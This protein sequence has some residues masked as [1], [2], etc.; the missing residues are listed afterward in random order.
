MATTTTQ[1]EKA[2]RFQE[3]H[4]RQG[5][6]F[7]PNPWDAGSAR[8]LA[9]LGFE[10][11][12]TSSGASAAVFGRRDGR[13]SRE[14]ALNQIRIIAAATDL[15]VSGDLEGGF[16]KDPKAV[17]ETIRLAAEAGLVGG[18][19]EDFTGDTTNPL[20]DIGLATERVAAAVEATKSLPFKFTL[21]ARAENFV[22]GK[23]DLD[24]TIRRLQA[25][26]KTGADV[27]FAPA[28][29][30]LATVRAVCSAVSKP[31]N[32]MVG[33][34]GKSFTAAELIEAGVK[35]ISFASSL[36][37]AAITGLV[38]AATEVRK[39]GTFRYLEKTLTGAELYTF[40]P[41]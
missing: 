26:E 37:R 31:V 33:I 25:Y 21:T 40:L 16:S 24:D 8:V 13:L 18:S 17:A 3:L 22:G 4:K 29:P 36:F 34:K 12:A 38:E 41:E 6:F 27:L 23:P 9:G 2:Q 39:T 5:A 10:A 19:I 7:V 14:E 28:L 11:F 30:D 20:Y 35:R 32:F 1:A 15:P